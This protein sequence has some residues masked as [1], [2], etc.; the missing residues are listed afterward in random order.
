MRG[1]VSQARPRPPGYREHAPTLGEVTRRTLLV[2]ALA[3]CASTQAYPEEL[4]RNQPLANQATDHF[5]KTRVSLTLTC[6]GWNSYRPPNNIVLNTRA[7]FES[8][9]PLLAHELGHHILGH[10]GGTGGSVQEMAANAT[11]VAVVQVW[12]RSKREAFVMV[13]ERPCRRQARGASASMAGHLPAAAELEDLK[14]RFK[15]P[16]FQCP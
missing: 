3:G 14:A 2:F 8:S 5:N 7:G 1:A 16:A 11:A 15:A 13:G 9:L 6:G 12:G 10:G 4:D